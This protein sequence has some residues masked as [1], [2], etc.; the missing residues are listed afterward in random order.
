MLTVIGNSSAKVYYD[1]DN[2]LMQKVPFYVIFL[3]HYVVY[4][5]NIFYSTAYVYY[6]IFGK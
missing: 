6:S 2:K 4:F 5:A 1:Y 3:I